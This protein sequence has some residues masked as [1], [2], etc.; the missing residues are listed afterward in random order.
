MYS[1]QS[2]IAQGVR[3]FPLE[4]S[5]FTGADYDNLLVPFNT[6]EEPFYSNQNDIVGDADS[7]VDIDYDPIEQVQNEAEYSVS[8][9]HEGS[10]FD[11]DSALRKDVF[12][13]RDDPHQPRLS[14]GIRASSMSQHQTLPEQSL[15]SRR[16][17]SFLSQFLPHEPEHSTIG[18]SETRDPSTHFQEPPLAASYHESRDL[19]GS[20]H[21]HDNLV[22]N[23]PL[24]HH[25]ATQQHSL[26]HHLQ[27][28]DSSHDSNETP[29]LQSNDYMTPLREES[30]AASVRRSRKQTQL[31]RQRLKTTPPVYAV[32]KSRAY[33]FSGPGGA[34]RHRESNRTWFPE[35]QNSEEDYPSRSYRDES[36]F[37]EFKPMEIPPVLQRYHSETVQQTVGISPMSLDDSNYSTIGENEISDTHAES[38]EHVVGVSDAHSD[39]QKD[40]AGDVISA[41]SVSVTT[42]DVKLD[43]SNLKNKQPLLRR[44]ESKIVQ[45]PPAVVIFIGIVFIATLGWLILTLRHSFVSRR[46]PAVKDEG[47]EHDANSDT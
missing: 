8:P 34:S 5:L 40:V 18:S 22:H 28:N 15:S 1:L 16:V 17:G 25:F 43:I 36:L 31:H 20:E 9:F 32:R 11:F 2:S 14:E 38:V 4:P 33:E 30:T 37:K 47:L 44:M 12:A 46:R 6:E 21:L 19:V 29:E 26:G 10:E 35:S 39:Q 41:K 42:K 24:A 13:N 45:L 3:D 23:F 7:F 27:D